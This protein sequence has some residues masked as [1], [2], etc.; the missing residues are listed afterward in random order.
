MAIFSR[1]DE[2]SKVKKYEP[3]VSLGSRLVMTGLFAGLCGLVA[4]FAIIIVPIPGIPAGSGFWIPAAIYFTLTLWFG[5]FGA[6]AGHIGTFIG[7]GPF[8][9][10]SFQVWANGALGDFFAPIIARVLF[11]NGFKGDPEL[12]RRKDWIGWIISVPIAACLA[13]MWIHFVNL[14]FGTITFPAWVLGVV[15]YTIGD[16]AAVFI[17]GTPMLKFGTKYVKSSAWYMKGLFS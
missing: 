14:S 10:F 11:I 7:M 15:A 9:G 2:L 5:I 6:I 13:S 4:L 1:V 16:T 3:Q 12:K 8:F 17:V